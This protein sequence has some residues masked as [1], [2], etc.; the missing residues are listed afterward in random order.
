MDIT[1]KIKAFY[2]LFKEV[3]GRKWIFSNY[4]DLMIVNFGKDFKI[5]VRFLVELCENHS[6]VDSFLEK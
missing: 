1:E 5:Y 6:E 2:L 3:K 4:G